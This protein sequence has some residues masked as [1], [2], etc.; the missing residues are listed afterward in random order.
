MKILIYINTISKFNYG[1]LASN[2]ELMKGF[3]ELGAE[4]TFVVNKKSADDVNVP[5]RV[6][7]LNAVGD[8]DRP[9][10]LYTTI[11]EEEPNIVI[12][13]MLTQI[14]TASITKKI[15]NSDRVKFIG[16]ERDLRPWHMKPWK[17]PYRFFIKR[18]YENMDKVIAISPAVKS[19]LERTFYVNE[20]KIRVIYNPID[21]DR[22]RELA[23][24]PIEKEFENFFRKRNVLVWVGR[25]DEQKEPLLALEALKGILKYK[26]VKLCYVGQGGLENILRNKISEY[27]LDKFVLITGFRENPYKYMGRAK[28]LIH[29]ARREGLGRVI[30]ESL[31]L[32]VPPIAFYNQHSGYKE[33]LGAYN[34]EVLIPFGDIEGMVRKVID[35]LEQN[36][37]YDK[38]SLKA[39]H[40][41]DQF[42]RKVIVRKLLE[43]VV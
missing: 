37:V 43:E 35:L 1:N 41:A 10:K 29:T 39:R 42:H 13:N 2:L 32:G 26:D 12:A 28:L 11:R 8:I 4:V 31:A 15:L 5:V 38:L 18:I 21:L 16:I 33:I 9:F 14:I 34:K 22:I 20:D 36:S 6:I 19:D 25:I 24:E 30:L 17:L 3:R 40:T 7:P 27:K 23:K